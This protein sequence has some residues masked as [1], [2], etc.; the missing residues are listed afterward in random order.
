MRLLDSVLR[1]RQP[2]NEPMLRDFLALVGTGLTGA[3]YANP[4]LSGEPAVTRTDPEIAF[5]WIGAAP[6]EGV[7]GRGFSTRWT[8]RLLAKSKTP[9]TFYVETD[10][11][12]R[13]TLT[14]NDQ[15]RVLIDRPSAGVSTMPPLPLLSLRMS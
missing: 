14:V 7:P 5:A 8:G 2:P 11:A 13:L 9:H 4:D 1:S 15:E 12:V 10:G 3:Y 6:A